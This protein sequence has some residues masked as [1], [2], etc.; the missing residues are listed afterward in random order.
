MSSAGNK[1]PAMNRAAAGGP[2]LHSAGWGCFPA[3][4]PS[5]PIYPPPPKPSQVRK[6]PVQGHTQGQRRQIWC[7]NLGLSL[8]GP[9]WHGDLLCLP[10]SPQLHTERYPKTVLF[11]KYLLSTY[12]TQVLC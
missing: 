9:G 8:E 2:W 12:S 11:K 5:N 4:A 7:L 6:S 1:D 10:G 3:L